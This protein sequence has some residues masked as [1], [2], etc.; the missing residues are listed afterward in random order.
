MDGSLLSYSSADA[1]WDR[2]RSPV[3]R[4]IGRATTI[5]GPWTGRR[6]PGQNP[7]HSRSARHTRSETD[8]GGDGEQP[9]RADR[10]SHDTVIPNSAD[11]ATDESS[12]QRVPTPERVLRDDVFEQHPHKQVLVV[13]DSVVGRTLAC[14]LRRAGYDPLL[15]AGPDPTVE[16]RVTSLWP[17]AR[18]TLAA[19]D[20]WDALTDVSTTISSVTV[21][22]PATDRTPTRF[23]ATEGEPVA[24]L[25]AVVETQTLRAALAE[26]LPDRWTEQQR[27]VATLSHADDGVVVDFEDGV[28]EWFDAVVDAGGGDPSFRAERQTPQTRST[29]LQY[30]CAVEGIDAPRGEIREHWGP[31]CLVQCLPAADGAAGLLRVTTTQAGPTEGVE[32]ERLAEV[33]PDENRNI[34]EE[35]AAAPTRV[36]QV[37][38]EAETLPPASW[39]T[40]RVACCGPAAYP[41]APASGL[42]ASLGIEDALA[43]VSELTRGRASTSTVDDYAAQRARRFATLRQQSAAAQTAHDYPATSLSGS[44]LARLGRRRSVALGPVLGPPLAALQRTESK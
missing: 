10:Q 37:R 6:I 4:Q 23:S 1:C 42:R 34:V 29:L 18:E 17:P 11:A 12:D 16:S 21:S 20:I 32:P 8:G 7:S 31:D 25:P 36:R 35:L 3:D 38:P 28:R 5:G 40:G 2:R 26:R 13:G 15:A 43:F 19:V 14:L 44:P 24:G 33:V 39:G 41:V 9:V 22:G 27:T 30:E